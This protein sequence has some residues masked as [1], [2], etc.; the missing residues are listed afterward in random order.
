[1]KLR[2]SCVD[3]GAGEMLIC[4]SDV[5]NS[6]DLSILACLL[7]DDGGVALADSLKC[8]DEALQL[9]EQV[10]HGK[11]ARADWDR[12]TWSAAIDCRCA[13]LRSLH[14][15]TYEETISIATFKK[16]LVGWKAFLSAAPT[17]GDEQEIA[18]D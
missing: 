16:A 17:S 10:E 7:M 9:I 14:D 18:I 2:F 13:V 5:T 3:A 1:M 11:L 6:D 4:S 15:D 12:E 8:V